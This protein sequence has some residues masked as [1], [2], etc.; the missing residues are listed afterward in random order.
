[1]MKR[2]TLIIILIIIFLCCLFFVSC[3]REDDEIQIEKLTGVVQ[4]GPFINGTSITLYELNTK[5][6]QSGRTFN[7]QVTSN[8]GSFAIDHVAIK[9]GLVE[10][11]ATGYYYDE[12]KGSLSSAPLTLYS[13]SDVSDPATFNINILTHLEKPR[14]ET[15]ISNKS[16]AEA[17]LQ[18]ETEI[19]TIFGFD[20]SLIT[21]FES[22]DISVE[23]EANAILLAISVILQG[24]RSVAALSELLAIITTDISADGILNDEIIKKELRNSALNLTTANIRS[25]LKT[26]YDEL[27]LNSSIPPFEKYIDIFLR[28]TGL[29]PFAFPKQATDIT[30]TSATLNGIVNA[31][32]LQTN[33]TF[34]YGSSTSYGGTVAATPSIV[35]GHL[36]TSVKTE[37]T[38]LTSG[39]EFHFRIKAVNALGT[40]Y[41]PDMK[42]S[43]TDQIKD[44]DQNIYKTVAIGNQLWMAENLKVTKYS[45]GSEIPYVNDP[46]LWILTSSGAQCSWFANDPATL[47]KY[48]RLYNYY[49]VTDKRNL[50]PTGWHVPSDAEWNT[51]STYLLTNGYGYGG[52]GTDIAKAL[53]ATSSWTNFENAG[54]IGNDQINNNASGFS[55]LPGGLRNLQGAFYSMGLVG[56]WYSTTSVNDSDAWFRILNYNNTE[57]GKYQNK[58]VVGASVRCLK[59]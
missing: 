31:N 58:K 46:G 19:M 53:A 22:L 32:D 11:V 6:V 17:K 10:L 26:R 39:A 52:S 20:P 4:K 5:L 49:A 27:G 15:L 23:D 47:T 59:D 50:C 1:M 40:T 37:I 55:A 13:L 16:F 28:S 14:I 9:T 54:C 2:V 24:S 30:S 41:S 38:G 33:V 56:A 57:F 29:K 7:A 43:N 3:Q 12:I 21:R 35:T 36:N 34:E 48:G 45:D 44:V 51:L 42:I 8:D 18:A 25:K